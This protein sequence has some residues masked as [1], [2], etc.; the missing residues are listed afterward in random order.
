MLKC[1]SCRFL[2]RGQSY[3]TLTCQTHS[4]GLW[5]GILK[6]FWRDLQNT[7]WLMPLATVFRRLIQ[8]RYNLS[9]SS[10]E[11][12]GNQNITM[13]SLAWFRA[14]RSFNVDR[15]F[16]PRFLRL[17]WKGKTCT[18]MRRARITAST[19]DTRLTILS[20]LFDHSQPEIFSTY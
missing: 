13:S 16:L 9:R 20:G 4:H 15:Y 19:S 6:G 18:P 3:P 10:E 11:V 5:E 8:D 1:I 17:L 12:D 2:A 7:S 14:K